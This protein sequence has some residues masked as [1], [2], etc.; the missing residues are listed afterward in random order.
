MVVALGA[1]YIVENGV[2]DAG[3]VGIWVDIGQDGIF[4]V[5]V[6]GIVSKFTK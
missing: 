1:G 5:N 3:E 6:T 2:N 4:I